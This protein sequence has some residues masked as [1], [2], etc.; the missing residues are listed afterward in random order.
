MPDS[1]RHMPDSRLVRRVGARLADKSCKATHF[2]T[3]SFH[4]RE[5]GCRTEPQLQ[6][7][8]PRASRRDRG[9]LIGGF[10]VGEDAERF[11]LFGQFLDAHAEILLM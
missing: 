8:Q 1:I 3:A 10:Y 5:R 6:A 2:A 4:G 11:E 7:P 9:W